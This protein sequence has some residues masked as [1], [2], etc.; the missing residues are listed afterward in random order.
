MENRLKIGN[1]VRELKL[2]SS[3]TSPNARTIFHTL[4]CKYIFSLLDV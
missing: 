4:K 2:G 3:F 1:E